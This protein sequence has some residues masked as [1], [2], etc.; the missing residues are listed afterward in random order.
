MNVLK[1][2]LQN[3]RKRRIDDLK[4]IKYFNAS[5]LYQRAF[6]KT[7][8]LMGIFNLGKD[9]R[10]TIDFT[11]TVAGTIAGCSAMPLKNATLYLERG[12]VYIKDHITSGKEGYSFTMGTLICLGG[13]NHNIEINEQKYLEYGLTDFHILLRSEVPNYHLKINKE[14]IFSGTITKKNATIELF[15]DSF[16]LK[17]GTMLSLSFFKDLIVDYDS[18]EIAENYFKTMKLELSE[19]ISYTIEKNKIDGHFNT[20]HMNLLVEEWEIELNKIQMRLG[21]K[22]YIYKKN[23]LTKDIPLTDIKSKNKE[24]S[25]IVSINYTNYQEIIFAFK[26]YQIDLVKMMQYP[27]LSDLSDDE[28]K[29]FNL[30]CL[31][32]ERSEIEIGLTE[33]ENEWISL[34]NYAKRKSTAHFTN[35]QVK[36]FQDSKALIAKAFNEESTDNEKELSIKSLEKTLIG[37]L[38]VDE[39]N[40]NLL[41]QQVGLREITSN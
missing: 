24:I 12:K 13:L 14:V 17:D 25:E 20:I 11:N 4:K 19:L 1:K 40:I 2:E 29:K 31:K 33:F 35:F 41:K 7:L 16:L 37:V 36:K 21:Y 30:L 10:L 23:N 34:L 8:R 9:A 32:I 26:R 15:E 28:V 3:K 18:F 39:T 38:P 6:N 5:K 22:T 27:I